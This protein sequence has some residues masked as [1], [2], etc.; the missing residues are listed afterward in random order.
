MWFLPLSCQSLNLYILFSNC[1]LSPHKAKFSL[2]G[3]YNPALKKT[4]KKKKK[5]A[6]GGGQEK[7]VYNLTWE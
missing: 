5:K 2:K 4:A 6:K 1:C 3:S 7:W